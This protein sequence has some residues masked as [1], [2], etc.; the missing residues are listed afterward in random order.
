MEL[1]PRDERILV[2]G[3]AGF[4]GSHLAQ[5]L[6]EQNEVIVYDSLESGKRSQV[7]EDAQLIEADLRDRDT[8]ARSVADV[9]RIF[10]EAALVSVEQSVQSPL[11]SHDINVAGTLSLL[12]AARRYDVPVILASSAAIYGEP[13]SVPI[14]ERHPT[15]PISP[16]GLEKLAIDQ[17]GRLFHEQYGLETVA[18]RYFNVYG[19][20]QAAT[21]YAGV[22]SA[23]TEQV[24][25]GGPI[26]IH[27]NGTQTRD[28][29]HVADVVQANLRAADVT[30]IGGRAFNIGTGTATSIRRLA[31]EIADVMGEEVDHRYVDG[32]DGDISESLADI[33]RAKSVLGYEP[34]VPLASGLRTLLTPAQREPSA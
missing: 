10:H 15:H 32:R 1:G 33:S 12:D 17:Y 6:S 22:I 25:S 7:P 26:T 2:T 31:I 21:D 13:E 4:I 20:R 5:A 28:F 3:G 19:P 27:G 30:G 29:V 14:D 23:F 16:Y 11:E 9:D 34:D 24:A 8:M 18:L